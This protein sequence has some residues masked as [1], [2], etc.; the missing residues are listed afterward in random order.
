MNDNYYMQTV[1]YLTSDSIFKGPT[2][3]PKTYLP[4]KKDNKPNSFLNH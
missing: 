2:E 1:F 3:V 4:D